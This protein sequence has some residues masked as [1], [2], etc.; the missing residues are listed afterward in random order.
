MKWKRKQFL[1]ISPVK[2]RTR[3]RFVNYFPRRCHFSRAKEECTVKGT[4]R[5][6]V[7]G[8]TNLGEG[9]DEFL[10]ADVGEPLEF[11]VGQLLRQDRGWRTQLGDVHLKNEVTVPFGSSVVEE[12]RGRGNRVQE[13]QEVQVEG[14][15]NANESVGASTRTR[16]NRDAKRQKAEAGG[17]RGSSSFSF[18]IS[19]RVNSKRVLIV[20][21]RWF[22]KAM[23]SYASR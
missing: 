1:P 4:W 18:S 22:L 5:N 21:E 6:G 10:G 12:K 20:V 17:P 3:V 13:V 2:E 8:C 19:R 23:P 16:F 7:C 14:A 11:H 15:R 9:L